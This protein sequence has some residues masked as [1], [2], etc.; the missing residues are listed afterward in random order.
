MIVRSMILSIALKTVL[1]N[2]S[3]HTH[4]HTHTQRDMTMLSNSFKLVG[5]NK[6]LLRSWDMNLKWNWL[7]LLRGAGYVPLKIYSPSL[8]YCRDRF[9][10]YKSRFIKSNFVASRIDS[11]VWSTNTPRQGVNI[12]NKLFLQNKYG[13]TN[14]N[15]INTL[16]KF[17]QPKEKP[18]DI[19]NM[20]I[21]QRIDKTIGSYIEFRPKIRGMDGM[22]FLNQENLAKMRVD[23][24]MHYEEFCKINDSIEQI[25]KQYGSLPM[26]N[27]GKRICIYFPNLFSDEVE[28]LM[29]DIGIEEGVVYP[30]TEEVL[31]TNGIEPIF[32]NTTNFSPILSSSSGNGNGNGNG[33]SISNSISGYI[34]V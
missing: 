32:S 14:G 3:V 5:I 25:F 21:N 12:V 18:Q 33:N 4:T 24:S 10:S 26:K 7:K 15:I 19:F 23:A 13:N 2:R 34:F 28:R 20:I 22:G 16:L 6:Y 8:I 9:I 31:S 1:R 17:A 11:K 29:I 27:D 30:M